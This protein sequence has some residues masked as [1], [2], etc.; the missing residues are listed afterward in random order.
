MKKIY[1]FATIILL[2]FGVL[3][4]GCITLNDVSEKTNDVQSKKENIT[5]SD[6]PDSNTETKQNTDSKKDDV[7]ESESLVK[8]EDLSENTGIK[9]PFGRM[10]WAVDAENAVYYWEFTGDDFENGALW[11]NFEQS[12]NSPVRLIC[13]NNSGETINILQIETASE[14]AVTEDRLFYTDNGKIAY[15]DLDTKQNTVSDIEGIILGITESGEYLVY[16]HTNDEYKSTLFTLCT[17]DMSVT[18][19]RDNCTFIAIHD[20]KVYYSPVIEDY[21]SA[22][23]GEMKLCSSNPDASDFR[24]IYHGLADLYDYSIGSACSI[25][26]IRFSD[27]F[28]YFSYGSVAGSGAF[29]Q[30]GNIIRVRY[31]GSGAELFADNSEGF[32]DAE[33]TVNPDGSI[34]QNDIGTG[35]LY[36]F[37]RKYTFDLEHNIIWLDE[38]TGAPQTVCTLFPDETYDMSTADFVNVTDKYVFFVTHHCTYNPEMNVGWRD[39]YEREKSIFYMVDRETKEIVTS[40]EF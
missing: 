38:T 28:I 31:D 9:K 19:I 35:G 20:G 32:V 21:E 1:V 12:E 13:R 14:F 7:N 23:R 37:R 39:Y 11:G 3:L 29:Y 5:E 18:K 27:E 4:S 15:F 2:A 25:A 30:G 22:S 10:G 26:Q 8:T 6:N 16:T 36:N 33:F 24:M 40:Y 17:S 34:T